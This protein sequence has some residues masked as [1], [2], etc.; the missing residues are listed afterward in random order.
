MT[1]ARAWKNF[2]LA[3]TLKVGRR[4]S[5]ASIIC[6]KPDVL[7]TAPIEAVLVGLIPPLWLP[8]LLCAFLSALDGGT[9]G[10]Y[11]LCRRARSNCRLHPATEMT[12][13]KPQ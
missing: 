1:T 9:G 4:W 3:L 2:R 5:A 10:S 6:A 12:A 11:R 7:S 13:S 8:V